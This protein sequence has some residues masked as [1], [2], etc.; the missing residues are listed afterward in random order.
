[1]IT[2]EEIVEYAKL[3]K[4][5]PYQT[6]KEYFQHLLLFLIYSESSSLVF[7]G[8][9]AIKKAYG[10][11]RFSEDLDFTQLEDKNYDELLGKISKRLRENFA[12]ENEVKKTKSIDQ[13][14]SSYR[15]KIIGPLATLPTQIEACYIYI[16]ISKR[17]TP[18]T[19][20][21][22]KISPQY[23]ELPEYTIIV[24]SK[25]EIVTEKVRAIMT[26]EKHRDVF[27]L[28]YL[29]KAG[30]AIR[31]DWLREKMNYY[32]MDFSREKFFKELLKFR[33]NWDKELKPLV[34]E[35]PD[36]ED[37]I[38]LIHENF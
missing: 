36:F 29:L 8:G 17:E 12:F 15:F 34:R 28:W 32:K 3:Y 7:K 26:R 38:K 35:V 14:G 24:M 5:P 9:T 2:K 27:D 23:K 37:V 1:M 6:E 18:K 20:E 33:K 11:S 13:I 22:I 31:F 19:R 25:E 21:I 16:E 4:V 30:T 10:L